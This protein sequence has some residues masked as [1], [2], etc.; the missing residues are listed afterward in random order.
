MISDKTTAGLA[1]TEVVAPIKK[2]GRQ[3][4]EADVNAPNILDQVDD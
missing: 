3:E 1:K 4:E 2:E